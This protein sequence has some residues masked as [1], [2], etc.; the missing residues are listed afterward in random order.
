[1]NK[2]INYLDLNLYECDY[3]LKCDYSLIGHDNDSLKLILFDMNRGEN[4]LD[5]DLTL[6]YLF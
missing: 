2:E 3:L 5:I 6:I 1:M 4:F